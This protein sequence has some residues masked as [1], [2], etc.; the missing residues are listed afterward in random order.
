ML[1]PLLES[2]HESVRSGTITEQTIVLNKLLNKACIIKGIDPT[3]VENRK[4][5]KFQLLSCGK[6]K[7]VSVAL[8]S[9]KSFKHK[10]AEALTDCD[11]LKQ[12]MKYRIH[13]E[14]S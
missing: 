12:H 9:E 13:P 5:M 4:Q 3:I 11:L 14:L 2:Y 10:R 7:P 1:N 8:H 6:I